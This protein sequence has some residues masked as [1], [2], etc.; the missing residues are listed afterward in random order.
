M[1]KAN[2]KTCPECGGD[3][4][5]DLSW[6]TPDEGGL[7]YGRLCRKCNTRYVVPPSKAGAIRWFV[8]S[9]LM[10][11]FGC[12]GVAMLISALVKGE[13][14]ARSMRVGVVAAIGGFSL[15]A[16]C[17]RTGRRAFKQGPTV[18]A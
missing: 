15:A 9:I 1:A 10:F 14:G 5:D 8:Y 7:P 18:R 11:G 4:Y 16:I 2:D 3:E 17:F 12:G 13:P 6:K